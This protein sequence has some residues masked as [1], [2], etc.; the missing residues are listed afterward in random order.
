MKKSKF[1]RR[2]LPASPLLIGAHFATLALLAEAVEPLIPDAA[3][4]AIKAELKDIDAQ[5]DSLDEFVEK[6]RTPEEKAAATAR[7]DV[8]KERF[9][10][11]TRDFRQ[12]RFDALMGRRES[13]VEQSN[14][15]SGFR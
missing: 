5:I 9:D 4:D 13:R 14:L 8:L 7:L 15:A 10:E 3:S 1:I 11:L 6:A 2:L 12:A